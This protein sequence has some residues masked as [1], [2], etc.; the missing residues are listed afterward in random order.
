MTNRECFFAIANG[1]KPDR[2]YFAPDITDWYLGNHRG[3]GEP[4]K[5]GPGVMIP[6]DDSIRYEHQE[7]LPEEFQNLSL[8]DFHRRYEWGM[9]CHIRDWYD[10]YYT[11]GVSQSTVIE[12]DK[13]RMTYS[14]P[15]GSL[16][17]DYRLAADGSW[18]SVNYWLKST[19]D[20]PLLIELIQGTHY[21]LRD[22]N[23][24]RVLSQ[25]GEM[26]QADIV[27]NRSPFGKILHEFLGFAETVFTLEDEPEM[28]EALM[29]ALTQNDMEL[30][31]LAAQSSCSVVLICDHADATLF[32]PAMYREYCIPFYKQVRDIMD[33]EG[34]YVSTHVDGNLK[35]L[36]PLLKDSGFHLLDGCTPAPMFD[37]QVEELADAING[38]MTAFVGIPSSLFCDNTPVEELC[39]IADR[40]LRAFHG[41]VIVNVGDILPA[42]G[43]MRKVIAVGEY[44]KNHPI[45]QELQEK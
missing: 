44:I 34:K 29:E 4:L 32:S 41:K 28:I 35:T 43:D 24:R 25:L 2:A 12:G 40:I 17:R 36:L 21:V 23:I 38:S 8:M 14:C 18:A 27:V 19:E 16:W 26:G 7:H 9:H 10:T 6:D 15:K 37:Y 31:H 11:N 22:D 33:K 3:E 13:M 30:I 1:K 45:N 42:V 39:K 20:I 5:Y